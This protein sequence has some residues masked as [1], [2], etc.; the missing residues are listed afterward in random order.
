M[1]RMQPLLPFGPS[2]LVEAL[3]VRGLHSQL[4]VGVGTWLGQ[5]PVGGKHKMI[6][7]GATSRMAQPH[8]QHSRL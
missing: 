8:G 5:W 4:T 6:S 3:E 7:L 2:F 1:L